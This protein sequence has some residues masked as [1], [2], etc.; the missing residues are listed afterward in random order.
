MRATGKF[1]KCCDWMQKSVGENF[2]AWVI[3]DDR[4][5]RELVERV[6]RDQGCNVRAFTDAVKA[7]RELREGGPGALPD[8][9]IT[10]VRL[11]GVDGFVVVETLLENGFPAGN[12][13]MMSGYWSEE[14]LARAKGM[15]VWVLKKPFGVGEMVGWIERVNCS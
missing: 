14:G 12:V 15:G 10:D 5:I 11:P 3:E 1:L 13:A 9:V 8:I 6:A 7:L 4:L 2:T